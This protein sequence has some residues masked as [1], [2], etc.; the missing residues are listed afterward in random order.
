MSLSD[1]LIRARLI[2]ARS[3]GLAGAMAL[4][5]L[6]GGCADNAEAPPPDGVT[7]V[8]AVNSNPTSPSLPPAS[9]EGGGMSASMESNAPGAEPAAPVEAT[10]KGPDAAVIVAPVPPVEPPAEP[11]PTVEIKPEVEPAPSSPA[12]GADTP[13]VIDEPAKPS[14]GDTPNEPAK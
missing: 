9:G 1:S 11:K 7:P 5:A 6:V 14:G 12:S 4:T 3:L 13:K 8:E 2:R 10:P